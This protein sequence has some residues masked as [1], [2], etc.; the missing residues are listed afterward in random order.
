MKITDIQIG[1]WL[2][3]TNGNIGKAQ[4]IYR[5]HNLGDKEFSYEIVMQYNPNG[6][7]YTELSLL[8][9]IPLTTEILEKNE[10]K[11]AK[12]NDNESSGL[13]GK[14]WSKDGRILV[15]MFELTLMGIVFS[16]S[17]DNSRISNIR[18]A[19][20]LQHALR[21]EGVDKEITI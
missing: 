13:C 7:C 16:V 17:G 5:Y 8:K 9:P 18:Y 10:F 1:D 3:N 2:Q 19:H 15:K 20:E 4:A 21:L 11:K 12:F 14:W 6:T